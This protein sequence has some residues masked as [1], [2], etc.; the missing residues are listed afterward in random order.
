AIGDLP[1]WQW[2]PDIGHDTRQWTLQSF[3][4]QQ[5]DDDACRLAG[6]QGD[7]HHDRVCHE[8]RNPQKEHLCARRIDGDRVTDTIDVCEHRRVTYSG[9]RWMSGN[10]TIGIDPRRLYL[11]VPDIAVDIAR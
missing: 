6:K 1:D 3:Q 7:P 2:M 11:A 8:A 9:K 4:E 10:I 5:Y